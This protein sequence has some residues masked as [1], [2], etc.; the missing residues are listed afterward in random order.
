EIHK[1]PPTGSLIFN[2]DQAFA[3]IIVAKHFPELGQYLVE[4]LTDLIDEKGFSPQL[5]VNS[6]SSQ[7]SNPPILFLTVAYNYLINKNIDFLKI[8]FPKLLNILNWW[9]TNRKVTWND[10]LYTWGG[11][12]AFEAGL[13]S[14]WD[15]SPLWERMTFDEKAGRFSFACPM[16][17]GFIL[18]ANRILEILSSP[19]I[20]NKTEEYN[21]L[22]EKRKQIINA[23]EENMWSKELEAYLPVDENGCHLGTIF[24]GIYY[25]GFTGEINPE[26]FKKSLKHLNDQNV[27]G[28]DFLI[29]TLSRSDP[30]FNGDGDYW[31]GRIW[32]PVNFLTTAAIANYSKIEANKI[33]E[34]SK[35]IFKKNFSNGISG[36]NYSSVSG[37]LFA[38]PG[39]YSRNC[40][41][42]VW[43]GL[44]ALNPISIFNLLH[45]N[46]K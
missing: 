6:F 27:L 8:C 18:L 28:G 35:S 15:N 16:A 24:P 46:T 2:W 41:V 31:R 19:K 9:E 40:P 13:E 42:Y 1:V 26:R 12:T 3:S 17:T 14:G 33:L 25:P 4:Q 22:R 7:I 43:G 30:D 20:L 36:E 23:I 10:H 32:P 38:Q 45:I 39:V 11:S 44:L 34:S 29:P 37:N 21:R 5:I